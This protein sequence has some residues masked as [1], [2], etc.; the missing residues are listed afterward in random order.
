MKRTSLLLLTALVAFSS[1][2][3]APRKHKTSV[4]TGRTA[5]VVFP[6]AGKKSIIRDKWGASRD[7]GIRRHKGIDIH[8][9]K[10]TPV[11]ALTDGRIVE[12]AQMPIGGKTLWLKSAHQGWTAYY[13]HLDKQYVREG[14]WVHKGQ[15]IGTVGNTGNARTTPSHLHFGVTKGSHWV[16][17][18]P[19]VKGAPKVLAAAPSSK[20]KSKRGQA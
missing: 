12:R 14:Q 4:R 8:A 17:P 2:F 20:K 9:R 5:A 3:A 13:A 7:G 11:V 18:L 10:G 6:V 1:A 19:Y 15:V 16:N